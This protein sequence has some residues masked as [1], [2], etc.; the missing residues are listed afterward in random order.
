[1]QDTR[2]VLYRFLNYS[3]QAMLGAMCFTMAFGRQD[4]TTLI[5]AAPSETILIGTLLVTAGFVVVRTGYVLATVLFAT[6]AY[7]LLLLP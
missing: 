2:S 3:S 6:G 1:M 7:A 5:H 4:I